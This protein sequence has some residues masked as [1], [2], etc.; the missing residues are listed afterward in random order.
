MRVHP[1][2]DWNFEDSFRIG[3]LSCRFPPLYL[4]SSLKFL[5]TSVG[6]TVFTTIDAAHFTTRRATV[7]MLPITLAA[8]LFTPIGWC[9]MSKFLASATSQGGRDV[10][11]NRKSL[12]TE[13]HFMGKS[14]VG[15]GHHYRCGLDLSLITNLSE[16][17][18]ASTTP[19]STK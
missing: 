5:T 14:R 3:N 8:V 1:G 13:E 6:F 12:V 19:L 16:R 4:G 15:E 17:R 18:W 10:F 7:L 2:I 11:L 9:S